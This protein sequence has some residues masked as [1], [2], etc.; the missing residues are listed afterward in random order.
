MAAPAEGVPR[1]RLHHFAAAGIWDETPRQ[2]ALLG[3]ADRLVGGA[4]V[5]SVV[6]D[7]ALP[8]KGDRSVGVALQ[9]ATSLGKTVNCQT[10]VSL[11][12]ARGEVPVAVG[13][14]LFLLES[15][16]GD[17]DRM[18]SAGVPEG[19]RAAR[20]K[21]ET[22]VA[23]INRVRAGGVC[24]GCVLADAGLGSPR[25]GWPALS[26]RGLSWAF[27]ISGRTARSTRPT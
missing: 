25:S 18:V 27:G 7:T 10:L 5:I 9:Y 20:T 23:E 8:K 11:K 19:L 3:E 24:F 1:D 16:T 14:A 17:A 6:D 26:A 13:L 21:L 4:D 12:L 22:A 15:W 2:L